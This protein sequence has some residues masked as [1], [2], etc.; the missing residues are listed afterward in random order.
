MLTQ[1]V[2]AVGSGSCQG[3]VWTLASPT[4]SGRTRAAVAH[5]ARIGLL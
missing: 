2:T 1:S 5:A 3:Q 4:I